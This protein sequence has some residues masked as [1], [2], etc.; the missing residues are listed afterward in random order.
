[1]SMLNVFV[2]NLNNNVENSG[3]KRDGNSGEKRSPACRQARRQFEIVNRP[4]HNIFLRA[5]HWYIR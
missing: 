5:R 1:M 4:I 3:T 2:H